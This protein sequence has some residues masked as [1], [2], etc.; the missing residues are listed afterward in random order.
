MKIIEK[1]VEN[2]IFKFAPLILVLSISAYSIGTGKSLFLLPA[3]TSFNL[4]TI[5]AILAGFLYTNQSVL[6]R[7]L[8]TKIAQK[9]KGTRI[10]D[11][12]NDHIFRGVMY[13]MWTVVSGLSLEI[14]PSND[15]FCYKAI[16]CFLQS[17]EIICMLFVIFYFFLSLQEM[18][19]LI[20]LIHKPND[21]TPEEIERLKQKS[22]EL[23]NKNQ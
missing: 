14:F 13:T 1:I 17:S 4:I 11:R 22:K 16:A 15:S 9:I 21:C 6:V 8:D 20:K 23:Y 18:N 19:Q 7:F 12:R 5:A 10:I 3:D 2:K